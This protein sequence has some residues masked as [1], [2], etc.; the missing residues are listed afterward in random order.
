MN[1]SAWFAVAVLIAVIG[2]SPLTVN[3]DYDTAADF[4]AMKT[5][6]WMPPAGNA[7]SDDLLVKR[8]RS[9]VNA[10]LQAKGRTEVPQ[11][12]DFLIAMQLSGKTTYGGSTGVGASVGIPVGRAGTISVG[13][14]KSKPH[15]KTEGTLVLDFVDAKTQ[16][17]VWRSTATA[18]V[19]P[20]ASPEEQQERINKVIAEM[21]LQFPPK[22]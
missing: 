16:S 10:Q 7:V 1:R 19:V 4:T 11:N 13:G 18:A 15:E 17:L 22:K 12:P 2:C 21:L 8:I 6:G 5:F 9:A 3:Y 14:G 20:T